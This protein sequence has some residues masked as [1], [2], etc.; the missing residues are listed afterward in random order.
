MK[1]HKTRPDQHQDENWQ[2]NFHEYFHDPLHN[3]QY[4]TKARNWRS[5]TP[6]LR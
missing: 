3:N 6:K 1:V 5:L 4:F 2:Q